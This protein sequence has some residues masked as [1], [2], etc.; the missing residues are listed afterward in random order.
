MNKEA[1]DQ[2]IIHE[3]FLESYPYELLKENQSALRL[4]QALHQKLHTEYDL[5]VNVKK[6]QRFIQKESTLLSLS[7]EGLTIQ[8]LDCHETWISTS[9]FKVMLDLR[10]I[11]DESLI[12]CFLWIDPLKEG[13]FKSDPIIDAELV[14]IALTFDDGPVLMTMKLIDILEKSDSKATFFL[15][16]AEIEKNPIFTKQIHAL[17]HEIGNHTYSHPNLK[18]LSFEEVAYEMNRTDKIIESVIEKKPTIMRPPYGEIN[19]EKLEAFSH[20]VI[21]WSLDTVDWDNHEDAIILSILEQAIDGD[22]I[23]M[24][25]RYD[26]THRAVEAFIQ[27]QLSLGVQFVSVSQLIKSRQLK[28]RIVYGVRTPISIID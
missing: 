20:Q 11:H 6:L 15:I 10:Y 9:S 21:Q 2:H 25:D 7:I 14:M 22:I 19:H 5:V 16:G 23:L 24:H 3:D 18:E 17:G 12:S 8:S 1:I 13:I 27:Q 4:A 26:H 28:S